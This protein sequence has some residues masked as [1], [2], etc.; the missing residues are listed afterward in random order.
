VSDDASIEEKILRRIPAEIAAVSLILAVPTGLVFGPGVAALFFIG[1]VLASLSFLSLKRW[2]FKASL[3]DR[4]KA[5]VAFAGFY[6][7]RLILIGAVFSTIILLYKRKAI[8]S[9]AGF[10][11]LILVFF[12]EALVAVARKSTWKS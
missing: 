7:L 8:A 5:V 6:V 2:L 10:S 1:G 3:G 12:A 11:V 4:K 9:A